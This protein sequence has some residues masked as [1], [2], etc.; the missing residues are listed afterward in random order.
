MFLVAW[1]SALRNE[2]RSDYNSRLKCKSK[3]RRYCPEK[4][5]CA[6]DAYG[7]FACHCRDYHLLLPLLPG[8]A[9]LWYSGK[10]GFFAWAARTKPTARCIVVSARDL[11]AA[12]RILPSISWCP[13]LWPLVRFADLK[14]NDGSVESAW[15]SSIAMVGVCRSLPML[16]L[17]PTVAQGNAVD[18]RGRAQ[19][20]VCTR[21]GLF[22]AIGF[23]RP[24]SR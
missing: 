18:R 14:A 8:E 12:E 10:V 24:R 5:I 11:P 3:T 22:S 19:P 4:I 23:G 13:L 21:S 16:G 17:A 2:A 15:A 7:A 9:L 20:G 6:R 1:L